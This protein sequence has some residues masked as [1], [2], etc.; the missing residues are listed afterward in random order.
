VLSETPLGVT[1]VEGEEQAGRQ[2]DSEAGPRCCFARVGRP[3]RRGHPAMGEARQHARHTSSAARSAASE[4]MDL[5]RSSI[6]LVSPCSTVEKRFL[7]KDAL[8]RVPFRSVHDVA[9]VGDEASR[10]PPGIRMSQE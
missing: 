2:D 4:A 6:A 3:L 5:L 7:T 10:A 1:A 9:A 8:P